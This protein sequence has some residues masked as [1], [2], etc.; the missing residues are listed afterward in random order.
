MTI[1][2]VSLYPGYHEGAHVCSQEHRQVEVL[3][4]MG[5]GEGRRGSPQGPLTQFCVSASTAPNLPRFGLLPQLE[6]RPQDLH[7]VPSAV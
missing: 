6:G 7:S 4:L 3:E 2:I 5:L 1:R